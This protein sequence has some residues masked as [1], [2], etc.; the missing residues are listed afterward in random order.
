MTNK[1]LILQHISIFTLL[2]CHVKLILV[3]ILIHIFSEKLFSSYSI[4]PHVLRMEDFMSHIKKVILSILLCLSIIILP[5]PNYNVSALTFEAIPFIILSQYKATADIGDEVC[6]IAFTSTGK[7][8]SWKSSNSSIASVNTYGI[9]TAKKAGTAVI[10]AKIRNAEASCLIT[11]NK[12]KITIN[13][14]SASM[15]RGETLHLSATT[16]NDS[17]VTWKSNRRSI[18]VVDERGKVTGIKPGE[19]IITATADG[20]STECIITI[21]SPT[22]QLSKTKIN[23]YRG[24]TYQLSAN[25]SSNVNPT[26]KTN[27]KSVAVIDQTGTIT[28]I[29][30]GM[31]TI[32]A[33]VDGVSKTCE[34]NV[35]KPDI[36]LSS[37]ELNLK[38]GAKA[39]I[40]AAVSSNNLPQ[41]STSNPNII[42]V[43]PKGEITAIQKGTAYIYA[44]EDGTKVRCTVHVTE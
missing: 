40:T 1:E 12:T 25:V 34:V 8:A 42:L 10:T 2:G 36:T 28:A 31:A 16:S 44:S 15:E 20:S 38:K 6:V 33:T 39:T 32:T 23:L 13:K 5:A 21:K 29:K 14:T 37:T 22:I 19:A 43:N 26:W 11:V 35:L 41:W 3:K 17:A 9:I 7:P 24:Q 4:L 30:N 18:A 27:K